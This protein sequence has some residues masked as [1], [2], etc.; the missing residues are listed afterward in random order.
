MN[1]ILLIICLVSF[2]GSFN[3]LF[4]YSLKEKST[5]ERFLDKFE[6]KT[7]PFEINWQN[8]KQVSKNHVPID[9]DEMD[10]FA[11]SSERDTNLQ[12]TVIFAIAKITLTTNHIGLVCEYSDGSGALHDSY[13]LFV[14]TNKGDYIMKLLFAQF[15]GDCSFLSSA[16]GRLSPELLLVLSK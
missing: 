9:K 15:S 12:G 16:S 3:S 13:Y 1:K 11:S 8:Q 4:N 5:W 7:L 10:E 6:F 2:F 14:F